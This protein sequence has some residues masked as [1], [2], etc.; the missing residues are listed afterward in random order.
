MDIVDTLLSCFLPL[1]CVT[2]SW[3][4]IGFS[5]A[6]GDDVNKS[7]IFGSPVT[8]FMFTRV[9]ST[10]A[11]ALAAAVPLTI[12]SMFQLTLA[13]LPLTFLAGVL[14]D[15]MSFAKWMLFMC[16]WHILVYCPLVHTLRHEYGLLRRWGILD[17][18]GSLPILIGSAAAAFSG[19]AY[20]GPRARN[21]RS[22]NS[23]SIISPP[24]CILGTGLMWFGWLSLNAGSAYGA[25]FLACQ[26]VVNTMVSASTGLLTWLLVEK[27]RGV[28]PSSIG[29]C[30]GCV[31]GLVSITAGSG[32]VTVGGSMCIGFITTCVCTVAYVDFK[33]W[34]F[35]DD[36][37]HLIVLNG[38]GGVCGF[39]LTAVFCHH[40][41]NPNGTNGLVYGDGH[42][43]GKHIALVL[44]L[45]PLL[46]VSSTVCFWISDR[47]W[48]GQTQ[49]ETMNTSSTG[50][51]DGDISGMKL[52]APVLN[53]L[54]Q[55]S[56]EQAFCVS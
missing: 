5:I 56:S 45:L 43:F 50:N 3:L 9:D 26:A 20:F 7:G 37:V 29:G 10:H 27:I 12:F 4:I 46:I 40:D 23:S 51:E 22:E 55:S 6:F 33:N 48:L 8:Y 11:P 14:I 13:I 39:L 18:G 38:V 36:P 15:R 19:I 35:I 24:Y 2:V 21:R 16:V 41:V 30:Y 28:K 44:V 32:Y 54:H 1:G 25:N 53:C 52:S 42:T 17:F 49:I 34:V 31:T 47:L